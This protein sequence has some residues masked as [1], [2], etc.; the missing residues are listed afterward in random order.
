MESLK[1]WLAT[2]QWLMA[3]QRKL[4]R[5]YCSVLLADRSVF[6]DTLF[7]YSILLANCFIES[8][9]ASNKDVSKCQ[10]RI[11]QKSSCIPVGVYL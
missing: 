10:K 2:F 9:L 8:N 3:R 5:P 6:V 1:Q 11:I 7:D 4:R